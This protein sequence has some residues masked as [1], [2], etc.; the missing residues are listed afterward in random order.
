[1]RIPI[2]APAAPPNE[3]LRL[4]EWS[5]EVGDF[6]D[7]GDALAELISA[8]FTIDLIAPAAGTLQDV[9]RQ[10]EQPVVSG[11]ILGWIESEST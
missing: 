4:G 11:D 7:V 8:G 3:P 6:V 1:M 2:H 5:V 9:L 10:P